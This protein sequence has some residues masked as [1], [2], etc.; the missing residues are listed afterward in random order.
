M[1]NYENKLIECLQSISCVTSKILL[2]IEI[3]K[4]HVDCGGEPAHI[5]FVSLTRPINTAITIPNNATVQNSK[6]K[7]YQV[8]QDA[9]TLHDNYGSR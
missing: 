3:E 2:E 6:L 9:C 5:T 1:L 8:E 7:I 4:N